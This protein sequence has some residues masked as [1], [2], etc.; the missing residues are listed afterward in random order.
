MLH[1][2]SACLLF[3]HRNRLHICL[4]SLCSEDKN[5]AWAVVKSRNE[6]L[7]LYHFEYIK[8]MNMPFARWLGLALPTCA[9]FKMMEQKVYRRGMVASNPSEQFNSAVVPERNLPVVDLI[10][11]L[12]GKMADFTFARAQRARIRIAGDQLLVPRAEL[13]HKITIAEAQKCHFF[14]NEV[15]AT[16]VNACVKNENGAPLRL[17]FVSRAPPTVLTITIC[18]YILFSSLH[19]PPNFANHYHF[20]PRTI[21]ISAHFILMD[22]HFQ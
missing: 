4:F 19:F 17:L 22:N 3:R 2:N 7:A 11:D 15:T 12:I 10:S 21:F 18:P 5:R 14:M 13:D 8:E 16:E 9:T 1:H 6:R 20:Y